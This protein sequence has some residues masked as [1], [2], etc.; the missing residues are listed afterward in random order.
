MQLDLF[1]LVNA[2]SQLIPVLNK[3]TNWI[4]RYYRKTFHFYSEFYKI[5]RAEVA[6]GYAYMKYICQRYMQEYERIDMQ[7]L[8][9]FNAVV[10]EI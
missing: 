1:R 7:L 8:S 2:Y 6:L 9:L 3:V 4:G 5:M 10:P